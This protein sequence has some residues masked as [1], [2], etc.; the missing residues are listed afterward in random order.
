MDSTTIIRDYLEES[1]M[2]LLDSIRNYLKCSHCQ[3]FFSSNTSVL[4][5]Q[6]CGRFICDNRYNY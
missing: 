5:L 6:C 1:E 3:Q 4:L 2:E